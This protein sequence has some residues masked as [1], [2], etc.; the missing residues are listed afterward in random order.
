MY[1]C[2]CAGVP[3]VEVRSCIARGARTVPITNPEPHLAEED[4]QEVWVAATEAISQAL[5]GSSVK[6]EEILGAFLEAFPGRVSLACSFQ[7]EESVLIEAAFA[8]LGFAVAGSGAALVDLKPPFEQVGDARRHGATP[9]MVLF[10]AFATLLSRLSGERERV[11]REE[12]LFYARQK[13]TDLLTQL[14]VNIQGYLAL[15]MIRKN[16]LELMKGVDRA[17]T[18]TVAA[19]RTAVIVAQA[20]LFGSLH[21]YQG[22]GGFLATSAVGLVMGYLWLFPGRNLWAPIV[23]HGLIDFISMTAAFNG[24]IGTQ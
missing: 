14:A 4:M 12:M 15:D 5:V 18:T 10:A 2:I 24:M 9:F 20:L 13:V 1:V 23:L 19:L 22:V 11:V 21:A 16:N 3:D 8:G 6:A 7:K 17:T